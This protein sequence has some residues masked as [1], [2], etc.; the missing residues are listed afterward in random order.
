MKACVVIFALLAGPASAVGLSPVTRVVELLQGLAKQV[1]KEG[2][3]EEGLYEDFVCWGKSIINQKT[4]SNAAAASRIDELE[5][6]IADL[7]SG[8]IELTSERADLEKDI[9]QLMADM[10][11]ATALRKKEHAD[12]LE[13]EDEMT[14][15]LTALQSAI[16]T[17][18]K[19]TKDH[20]EGVL[21][22]VRASLKGASANGGMAALAERQASLRQAAELGERFLAKADATFLRRALLGDVP[23]VDWKKLNRKATFKMA[24]KARSFKI[25]GVLKKMHQTFDI[26]LKDAQAKEAEAEADYK[27]LTE[28]KQGQLDAAREALTKMESEGG[29]KGM[30]RQESADEVKALKEQVAND[31]KFIGQTEKALADKKASWKVR[32]E[33]RAGELAAISKAINILHNDDARDL[34]KKSFSSQFLQVGQTVHMAKAQRAALA[35]QDAARRSGDT[36]LLALVPGGSV[37]TKFDPI[38][39]AIDKM[40]QKLQDEEEEDL[41]IKQTCEKDRMENTRTAILQSRQI[42]EQTDKITQLTSFIEQCQK[43]IEELKAEHAKTK[44]A[45]EKAQR[46]RDDENA[47]WKQTDAD[48][49]AAAETVASA[50]EVL[51]G[52]YKDN[53]LVFVQKQGPVTGMEAGD[54]PPP[55]PPTWEGGYGGKT[56]ESQGIV[57]IMEMVHD[58][59][60]KDRKDAKADE[61]NAQSEFDDFKT[62]SE[63]KMKQ[64]KA[65]EEKTEKDMGA[66]ET[67]KVDTEKQRGTTKGKLDAMLGTIKDINPNCEYYEVNYPMRTKNR[68]IEIDGLNKAKAILEGGVF[69]EGPDPNREIKPG[70]AFLQRRK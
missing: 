22:A 15:A 37:K 38:I 69:D 17:L 10:E 29:A 62:D 58:D 6:Y 59:I 31:E 19:A 26:N 65:D 3:V 5:T 14:K 48:D 18:D 4:A 8:R 61:D 55:P 33:L 13:A 12:F 2:K 16:D 34:F 35:L 11:E 42:D 54:A 32:S 70:D 47:E 20:K 24:Y 57:A 36:R 68:Q 51:E 40:V 63:N 64:L 60:V 66:A 50:K 52:F 23:K 25:Q 49:K 46:M 44:E 67:D 30:S 27:K 1:E 56:G 43:T 28:A 9:A 53:G 21:L 39:K 41:D 7:D 45:L